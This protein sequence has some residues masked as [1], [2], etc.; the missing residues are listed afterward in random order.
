[1]RRRRLERA[2]QRLIVYSGPAPITAARGWSAGGGSGQRPRARRVRRTASSARGSV[3]W[4]S[5]RSSVCGEDGWSAL[6]S[7]SSSTLGLRPP[8]RARVVS[9]WRERAAST[10]AC[11][12]CCFGGQQRAQCSLVLRKELCTEKTVRARYTAAHCLL[13]ACAHPR[14]ARVVATWPVVLFGCLIA[15][16]LVCGRGRHRGLTSPWSFGVK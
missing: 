15:C 7:G 4:C 5:E 1:M 6:C 9:R 11:A 10:A 16:L 2:M 13:R 14:L 3:P 8:R 12:A